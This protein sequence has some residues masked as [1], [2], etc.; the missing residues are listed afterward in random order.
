MS[1]PL[2][3]ASAITAATILIVDDEATTGSSSRRC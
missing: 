1:A 3:L 2:E